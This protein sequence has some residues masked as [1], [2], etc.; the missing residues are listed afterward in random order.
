MAMISWVPMRFKPV[1]QT[2]IWGGR[3]MVELYGRS[4]APAT[5]PVAESWELSDRA[6]GMSVAGT[7]PLA[8]QTLR[9][10]IAEHREA[11]LG[12][13]PAGEVF[14]LLIKLLDARE[15]LSVQVHPDDESARQGHGEAKSEAWY[16]LHAVPG[17]CVYRGLRPGVSPAEAGQ[18]LTDGTLADKLERVPV[19]A[20]DLIYVPGGTVHAIGAGCML[21]E[22]QQNSNTTY[23][24][25]DWNRVGPDGQPRA[26]HLDAAGQVARWNTADTHPPADDGRCVTPYFTI[27]PCA[28]GRRA[29]SVAD[30][31][32]GFTVL[33]VEEGPVLLVAG[34]VE[35]H[36]APG[37]TWLLPAA[38]RQV[39]VSRVDR[40]TP[41]RIVLIRGG[42]PA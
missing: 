38:L 12:R 11:I 15:T 33:F 36:V 20:G 31:L 21:L 40:E 1:Y 26:L 9:S 8:G 4:D 2:Y 34:G 6:D 19:D 17:A 39:K 27:E 42:R 7:G 13:T 35:Q 10:I 37:T 29:M 5:G 14:P 18:S 30:P 41:A 24:I 23:R 25:F 22:V 16:V 32:R 28:V 3:G